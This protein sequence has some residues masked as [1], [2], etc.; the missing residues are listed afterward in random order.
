MAA[1]LHRCAASYEAANLLKKEMRHQNRIRAAMEDSPLKVSDREGEDDPAWKNALPHLDSLLD[2]LSET[3]R[4]LVVLH[5]LQGMPH[6]ELAV[7]VGKSR[8]AVQRRCHRCLDKLA[9]LLNARGMGISTVTLVSM[10]ASES[11]KAVPATLVAELPAA[12]LLARSKF[13]AI[14]SLNL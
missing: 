13:A 2:R 8:S 5:Y 1:W 6:R 4:Q 9:N 11:A 10:F 14:P 3:D 7:V 12:A